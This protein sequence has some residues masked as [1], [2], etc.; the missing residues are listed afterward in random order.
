M[1]FIGKQL[2]VQKGEYVPK[3]DPNTAQVGDVAIWY[4]IEDT[5]IPI[6]LVGRISKLGDEIEI[7]N[8]G[9]EV[10]TILKEKCAVLVPSEYK[11]EDV[12]GL[13]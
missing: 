9:L 1:A 11:L 13:I 12:K 2:D 5:Q 8:D 3:V 6:H 10:F 7:V 4:D